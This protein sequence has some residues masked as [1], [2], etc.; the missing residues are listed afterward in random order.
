VIQQEIGDH[1]GLTVVHVNRV[2]RGLRESG[3]VTLRAGVVTIHDR[4]R[5]RKI[6]IGG[7]DETAPRA[8]SA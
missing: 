7:E 2:L 1:L 8:A 5:L 3:V 4:D 6:A